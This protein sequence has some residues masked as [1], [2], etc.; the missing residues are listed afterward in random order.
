[1]ALSLVVGPLADKYKIYKMILILIVL[2]NIS[3]ALILID[4]YHFKG[5]DVSWMYYA[6]YTAGACLYQITDMLSVT[7]LAKICKP[8]TRGSMFG[9]NA[10]F[11]SVTIAIL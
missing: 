9:F 11:G 6:G 2:L 10:M 5:Q 3:G 7:L 4:M 8:E 1:M